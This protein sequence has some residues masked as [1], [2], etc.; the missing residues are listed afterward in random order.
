MSNNKLRLVV[1]SD[2]TEQLNTSWEERREELKITR[3]ELQQRVMALRAELESYRDQLAGAPF[4]IPC[5][6]SGPRSIE[7]S[8]QKS[9]VRLVEDLNPL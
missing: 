8:R 5:D 7:Y 6:G 3:A 1:D 9:I 2:Q 4:D